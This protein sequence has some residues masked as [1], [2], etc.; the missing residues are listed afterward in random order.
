MGSVEGIGMHDIHICRPSKTLK[1]ISAVLMVTTVL[2]TAYAYRQ[3]VWAD[4]LHKQLVETN[5]D[6]VKLMNIMTREQKESVYKRF[7]ERGEYRIADWIS[8]Q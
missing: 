8:K 7:R 2:S 6:D 4:E 1:A 5:L 3:I